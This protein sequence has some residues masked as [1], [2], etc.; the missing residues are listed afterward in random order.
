MQA[1]FLNPWIFVIQFRTMF[2]LV[3]L[4]GFRNL[5]LPIRLPSSQNKEKKM[6][7]VF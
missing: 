3:K 4:F 5:S 1:I 7:N 6:N 2:P